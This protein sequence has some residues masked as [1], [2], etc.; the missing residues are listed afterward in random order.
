MQFGRAGNVRIDALLDLTD[1]RRVALER[2]PSSGLVV[3]ESFTG[4]WTRQRPG[5][6]LENGWD[7]FHSIDPGTGSAE[8]RYNEP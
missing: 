2:P 7:Y 3:F 6:L 5:W 1:G 8:I 4:D